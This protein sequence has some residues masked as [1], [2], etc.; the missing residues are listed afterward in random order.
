MPAQE[1]MHIPIDSIKDVRSADA[2]AL[3]LSMHPRFAVL[4]KYMSSVIVI[5]N[6]LDGIKSLNSSSKLII[7]GTVK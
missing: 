6:S 1:T 5:I 3:V 2:D 7:T 4:V